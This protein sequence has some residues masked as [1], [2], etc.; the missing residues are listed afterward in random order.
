[1]QVNTTM[2]MLVS[3]HSPAVHLAHH[4]CRSGSLPYTWGLMPNIQSIDLSRN[5]ISG[6]LPNAWSLMFSLQEL[7]LATN[8]LTG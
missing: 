1:M 2:Q 7:S 4:F 6:P 3:Y 8:Q 5:F